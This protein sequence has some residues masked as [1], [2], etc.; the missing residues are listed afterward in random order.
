MKKV[1]LFL[2]ICSFFQS[3]VYAKDYVK[4]QMQEAKAAQKYGTT[5]KFFEGVNSQPK[6]TIS[7]EIKD[8]KTLKLGDYEPIPTDKYNSKIAKDDLKYAQIKSSFFNRKVDNFNAQPYGSDFYAVYR[9][10]EKIIRANNLDY[11]NWRVV[12]SKDSS[13]NASSSDMN[14]I[15]INTGLLDTFSGNEDALAL[16]IAHEMGH[17]LLGH[18]ERAKKAYS[19]VLRKKEL[20]NTYRYKSDSYFYYMHYVNAM[21]D[22]RA[23]C[24]K[25]EY[26]ADIE[27]AKLILKAGYDPVKAR[28]TISFINT[29]GSLSEGYS[30]HPDPEKRLKNYD[31][32]SKYFMEEEW[33]QQGRYNIYN[34]EVLQPKASSDRVSFVINKGKSKS[35]GYYYRPENVQDVLI[36]MGYKSYVY[37]EFKKAEDYFEKY[38]KTNKGNPMVYLY[39]SYTEECLYKQTNKPKYLQNA[40]DYASYAQK[41][42][43]SDKYIKEQVESL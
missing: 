31:D 37:G 34:S 29:I 33:A 40:K 39:L 24:R 19:K 23:I 12:I 18:S 1:L 42:A 43:P 25:M 16:A 14:C 21:R 3:G 13:F 10:T 36:R 7:S 20:Y 22:Y 17:S 35:A 32:N 41:L 6:Y 38:L 15:T 9:I 26:S 8:P 4:M 30:D 2:L 27:G 11:I 5:D 28:E